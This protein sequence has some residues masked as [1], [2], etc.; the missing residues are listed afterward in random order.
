[1]ET[2]LYYF[3][4][5]S[6]IGQQYSYLYVNHRKL[7]V[8]NKPIT[9]EVI[10][11]CFYGSDKVQQNLLEVYVEHRIFISLMNEIVREKKYVLYLICLSA[12]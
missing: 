10:K 4:L 2:A 9:A 12:R 5:K 8:D 3:S 7:G 6:F 1:M 11:G